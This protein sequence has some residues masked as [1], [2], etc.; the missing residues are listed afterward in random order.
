MSLGCMAVFVCIVTLGGLA[1]F[2]DWRFLLLAIALGAA[3]YGIGEIRS[4]KEARRLIETFEATFVSFSGSMPQMVRT[5]SYGYPHISVSF[6]TKDDMIQAFE[7][8]HLNA[9]KQAVA[10]HFAFF[11]DFDIAKGFNEVYS[12]YE[13]DF[14]ES[15]KLDP[16]GNLWGQENQRLRDLH[17]TD[18]EESR[19]PAP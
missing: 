12:G 13:K 2:V 16:S 7:S 18:E 6:Q 17:Y 1:Y 4:R 11:E 14:L 5:F 3:W 19:P 8:G 15:M 9:F 10:E